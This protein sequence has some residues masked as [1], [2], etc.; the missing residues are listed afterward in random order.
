MENLTQNSQKCLLF[1]YELVLSS[2]ITCIEDISNKTNIDT[3]NAVQELSKNGYIN[4]D[5]NKNIALT[6]K[7]KNAVDMINARHNI[8][9]DF[10]EKVL[11]INQNDLDKCTQNLEYY[12]PEKA[13]LPLFSYITTN[14]SSCHG[15]HGGCGCSSVK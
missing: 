1:I 3:T 7:G 8:V 2:G 9:K 4:F 11:M 6:V 14:Q 12:V 5:S 10:L 15:C 13:L